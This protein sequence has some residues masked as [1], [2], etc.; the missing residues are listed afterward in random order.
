MMIVLSI[1]LLIAG[2]LMIFFPNMVYCLT[3]IWKS[4]ASSEPSD[5]YLIQ[6]RIGGILCS[7]VGAAGF[8]VGIM[9]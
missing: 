6:T 7:L 5:L 3:E 1:L 2:V 8:I 4:C 9:L